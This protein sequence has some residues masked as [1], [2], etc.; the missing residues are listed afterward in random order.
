[1]APRSGVEAAVDDY[2]KHIRPCMKRE[3]KHWRDLTDEV[4]VE[5]AGLGLRPD[6]SVK[7]PHQYLI[8]PKTFQK[9][10]KRLVA[11]RPKLR[12]AGSFDQLFE[13]V[14]EL[15]RAISGIGEL[16][17]YDTAIRI[18]A[19]FNLEPEK[20]YVHAGTRDGVRAL[21][22]DGRRPTIEM[23]ELPEPI[24]R[25]LSGREAEDLLCR[26]KSSLVAST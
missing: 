20:V 21:G 22:L 23:R 24:S 6:G 10:C 17:V 7:H 8:P 2:V 12:A 11:N 16:A 26:Y 25:R 5:R 15:I 4:A 19:R 9:S 3:F 1:V 14:E 18:G 13:L